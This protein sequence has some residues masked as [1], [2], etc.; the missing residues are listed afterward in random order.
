[1]TITLNTVLYLLAACVAILAVLLLFIPFAVVL[2]N[3]W[4][5]QVMVNQQAFYQQAKHGKKL[6]GG[7][8]TAFSLL[9][10]LVPLRLPLWLRVASQVSQVLQRPQ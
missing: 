3:R 2:I 9:Q 5:H 4:Q 10:A 8:K 6:L 1:M 7:A